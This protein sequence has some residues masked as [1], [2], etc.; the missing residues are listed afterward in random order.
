LHTKI[1]LSYLGD[2]SESGRSVSRLL[3]GTTPDK[4][5]A[6]VIMPEG[7]WSWRIR[8]KFDRHCV[9]GVIRHLF[10]FERFMPLLNRNDVMKITDALIE[11]F[12]E[13]LK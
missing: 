12:F 2:W 13:V 7:L 9:P 1:N 6:V 10:V 4:V 3:K 11:D 8:I 5:G